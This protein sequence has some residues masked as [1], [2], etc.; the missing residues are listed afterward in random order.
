MP[1]L[2]MGKHVG[3]G[4]VRRHL[5]QI[6]ALT[7]AVVAVAVLAVVAFRPSGGG[8]GVGAV[9]SP[10]TSQPTATADPR[11]DEV[12][13]V[14]RAF[15]KAYWDSA[16]TGDTSSV[17]RLTERDSQAYGNAAI[18][19]TLSKTEHHNFIA[20]RLDIDEG[21]W[22]VDIASTQASVR[23]TYRLYGHDAEWPTLAPREPER[24]TQSVVDSFTLEVVGSRWLVKQY[25]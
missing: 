20:T 2:H 1:A 24:E 8:P 21:A 18:A 3:Q 25:N 23:I 15:V 13:A 7:V 6:A 14:A 19:A 17:D 5:V 10:V 12:K 11:V 4:F 22:H 9:R 16:K